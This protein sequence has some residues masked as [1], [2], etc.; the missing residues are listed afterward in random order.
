[1]VNTVCYKR[2]LMLIGALSFFK[3]DMSNIWRHLLGEIQLNDIMVLEQ[4]QAAQVHSAEGVC[5]AGPHTKG[6]HDI[7][8]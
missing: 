4:V 7:Y 1:M 5:S 6:C 2:C 8:L 3:H